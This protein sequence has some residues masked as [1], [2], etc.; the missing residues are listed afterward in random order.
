[1]GR[2]VVRRNDVGSQNAAERTAHRDKFVTDDGRDFGN[3]PL[4]R[5]GSGEGDVFRG[6][7]GTGRGVDHG[8]TFWA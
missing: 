1:M 5:F 3:H 8:F 6:V 4:P 2:H 7:G